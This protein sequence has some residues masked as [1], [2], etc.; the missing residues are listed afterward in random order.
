MLKAWQCR[1]DL[2]NTR[3]GP[4]RPGASR[5]PVEVRLYDRVPAPVAPQARAQVT[6]RIQQGGLFGRFSRGVGQPEGGDA[7]G[8]PPIGVGI[9]SQDEGGRLQCSGVP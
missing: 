8:Y 5:E 3:S 2:A 4:V 1:E 7:L 6:D 9:L